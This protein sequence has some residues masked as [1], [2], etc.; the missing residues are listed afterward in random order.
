VG[1]GGTCEAMCDLSFGTLTC[2]SPD[3]CVPL[4]LG[5]DA[6]TACVDVQGFCTDTSQCCSG[7]C[8]PDAMACL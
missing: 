7:T 3:V 6:C 5:G 4:G 8:D 1:D 2:A